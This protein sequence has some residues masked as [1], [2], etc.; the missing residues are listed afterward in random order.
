[1]VY[2]PRPEHFRA[3]QARLARSTADRAPAVR[4]REAGGPDGR[5]ALARPWWNARSTARGAPSAC[6]S[7]YSPSAVQLCA[8]AGGARHHRRGLL[9]GRVATS[10]GIFGGPILKPLTYMEHGYSPAT[11]RRGVMPQPATRRAQSLPLGAHS[12]G[13]RSTV[14][15]RYLHEIAHNLQADLGLWIENREALMVRLAGDRQRHGSSA[16]SAA[17]TKRSSPTWRRCC[18]AARPRRGAWRI[19]SGHPADKVM[20]YRP[21]GP[22][23]TGYLR[24]LIL[25]EMLRRLGFRAMRRR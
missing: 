5:R 9:Y 25:A 12:L 18:L 19:F 15:S 14:A 13:S 22:H 4:L 11:M 10:P 20:T 17:G 21:G 2:A 6:S 8:G 1:M 24:V 3:A 16:S 23:P 7:R